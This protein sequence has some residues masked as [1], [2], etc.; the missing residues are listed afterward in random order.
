MAIPINKQGGRATYYYPGDGYLR[1]YDD[2]GV[3]QI[4]LEAWTRRQDAEKAF[5]GGSVR[6]V[7][8]PTDP[9]LHPQSDWFKGLWRAYQRRPS[10]DARGP[11]HCG[12]YR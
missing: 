10:S 2:F 3:T 9:P 8:D 7:D 4:S 5:W 6:W 12:G 1:R 11:A